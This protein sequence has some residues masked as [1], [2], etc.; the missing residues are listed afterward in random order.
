MDFAQSRSKA[1]IDYS[2]VKK[3]TNVEAKDNVDINE[4]DDD[5]VSNNIDMIKAASDNFVGGF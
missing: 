1:N 4:N 5:V 3:V 2:K